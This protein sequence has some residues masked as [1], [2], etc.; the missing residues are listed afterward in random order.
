MRKKFP[1]SDNLLGLIL[2]LA[3]V[4]FFMFRVSFFENMELMFYDLRAQFRQKPNAAQ[5][6]DEVA[7]VAIDDESI[8]KIGRWPWP[9]GRMAELIQQISAL[10][11]KVV[12]INLLFSEPESNQGLEELRSLEGVY[13]GLLLKNAKKL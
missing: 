9:R 7:I 11:P 10:E 1:L 4:G 12:A 3:V 13:G 6:G 2:T 8:D 5:R